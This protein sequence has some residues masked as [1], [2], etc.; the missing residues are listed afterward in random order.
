MTLNRTKSGEVLGR[1][2]E[3]NKQQAGSISGN[4]AELRDQRTGPADKLPS[5]T[6]PECFARMRPE[7]R[8]LTCPACGYSKCG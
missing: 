5:D 8:C 1:G 2:R 6:C 7:G 3:A 4:T